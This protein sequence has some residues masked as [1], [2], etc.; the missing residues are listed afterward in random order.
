MVDGLLAHPVPAAPLKEMGADKVIAV[1]FPSHWVAAGGPKHFMEVI[2]QCFSIAQANV[3]PLWQVH[4]DVVL[5]PDVSR[6]AYDAF[7]KAP[8]LVAA[9]EAAA[10]AALPQIRQ[11]LGTAELT[12]AD[13]KAAVPSLTPSTVPAAS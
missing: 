2:G 6:Y 11:W 5:E 1:H 3:C 10:H 8:E 13:T 12:A 9:G 7:N 4:A